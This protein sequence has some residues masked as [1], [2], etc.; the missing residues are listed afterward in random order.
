MDKNF[1]KQ[2]KDLFL[3]LLL[4]LFT[5]PLFGLSISSLLLLPLIEWEVDEMRLA[6]KSFTFFFWNLLTHMVCYVSIPIF[7][8]LAKN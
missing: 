6:D 5:V 3:T 7:T 2:V 4:V 8:S 1:Q